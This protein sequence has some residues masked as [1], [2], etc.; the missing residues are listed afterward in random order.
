MEFAAVQSFF[1]NDQNQKRREVPESRK[2]VTGMIP[3]E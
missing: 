2:L 1:V 3:D